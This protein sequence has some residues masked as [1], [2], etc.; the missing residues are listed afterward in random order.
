M[1]TRKARASAM[2]F[3]VLLAAT[4]ALPV[5][6]IAAQQAKAM[7]LYGLLAECCRGGDDLCCAGQ[8]F[9]DWW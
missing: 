6:P 7:N 4:L 9:L 3:A 5:A 1:R 8:A 2:I